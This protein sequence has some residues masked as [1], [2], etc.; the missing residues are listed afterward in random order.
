M[1]DERAT[2]RIRVQPR[3]SRNEI[4]GWKDGV[5]HA[6]LTA[7]PVEGAANKACIELIADQLGVR[8][9]QV[10]LAAGEK[11]REKTL[12]VKGISQSEAERLLGRDSTL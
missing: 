8:R 1:S 11:S 3:A 2:L 10:Q 6:R 9:Y 5:L 4:T 12:E 7:P